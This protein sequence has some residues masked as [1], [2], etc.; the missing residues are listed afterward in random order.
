[1]ALGTRVRTLE[2]EKN[3]LMERLEEEEEKDKEMIRQT[4]T[5]SQQVKD[6]CRLC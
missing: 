5:H 2:E 4:Q 3:A 1:M 6:P